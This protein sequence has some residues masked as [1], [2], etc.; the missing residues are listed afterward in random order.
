[1]EEGIIKL[2]SKNNCGLGPD[3]KGWIIVYFQFV[4]S[5]SL[6]HAKI[7]HRYSISPRFEGVIHK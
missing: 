2:Y 3:I 5:F 7:W 4:K 1:M 6:I